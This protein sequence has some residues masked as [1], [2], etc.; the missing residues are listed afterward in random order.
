MT[1]FNYGYSNISQ[2]RYNSVSLMLFCIY[3][4]TIYSCIDSN[5]IIYLLTLALFRAVILYIFKTIDWLLTHKEKQL[6]D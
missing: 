6:I 4:N 2:Y 3:L 5:T 1:L